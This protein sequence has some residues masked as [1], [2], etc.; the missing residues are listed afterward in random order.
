MTF[1]AFFLHFTYFFYAF[2]WLFWKFHLPWFFGSRLTI[3]LTRSE[4]VYISRNIQT[5]LKCTLLSNSQWNFWRYP[6]F[7]IATILSWQ[8]KVSKFLGH[9][10]TK[11]K[12]GSYAHVVL[13]RQLFLFKLP[14][15][16]DFT[17]FANF[18]Q[19]LVH[20]CVSSTF[21]AAPLDILKLLSGCVEQANSCPK[22]R[23]AE[24]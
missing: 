13:S 18:T 23:P 12:S 14:N 17:D 6:F 24:T 15:F 5:W 19:W 7:S 21:L 1:Q 20:T 22:P 2:Q 3:S 10:C 9:T 11:P 4:W 16:V 8:K